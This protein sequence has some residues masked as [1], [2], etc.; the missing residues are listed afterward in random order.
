NMSGEAARDPLTDKNRLRWLYWLAALAPLV[1]LAVVWVPELSHWRVARVRLSDEALTRALQDVRSPAGAQ[2]ERYDLPGFKGWSSAQVLQAAREVANGELTLIDGR[3]ARIDPSFVPRDLDAAPLD[4]E[5]ACLIVPNLHLRAY[6]ATGDA[7]YLGL[8]RTYILRWIDFERGRFL[9]RGMQWNDHA[10]AERVFVLTGF[11]SATRHFDALTRE[12]ARTVLEVLIESGRRL[13]KPGF[14]TFRTNHGLM[15]HLAL[16][17][18]GAN[19]PSMPEAQDMARLAAERLARQLEYYISKEGVILE[20]SAGYQEFGLELLPLAIRELEQLKFE[21]PPVLRERY[22][23]ALD[24]YAALLRPDGSLPPWGDTKAT[25]RAPP[26]ADADA[27]F[28]P[29]AKASQRSLFAPVAGLAVI[30]TP[31][32]QAGSQALV[33]WSDFATGAHKQRDEMSLYLWADGQEVLVG[34]G[35]WPYASGLWADAVGWRGSNAPHFAGEGS[36]SK[37]TTRLLGHASTAQLEFFDL[38]RSLDSG[39]A[40]RRQL[41]FVRP[42]LWIVLDS[43]AASALATVV[44]WT[45]GA[46]AE[47]RAAS[48]TRHLVVRPAAAGPRFEFSTLGC[49]GGTLALQRGSENAFAGWT[50]LS[51]KIEPAWSLVRQCPAGTWAASVLT[52]VS[53]GAG[54]AVRPVTVEGWQ[55]TENWQIS[56]APGQVLAHRRGNVVSLPGASGSAPVEVELQADRRAEQ[57][58]AQINAHYRAM[59]AEFSRYKESHLY[60][61]YKVTIAI[62]ALWLAQLLLLGW[63][64][65]WTFRLSPVLSR[66]LGVSACGFWLLLAVWLRQVYF[67][68]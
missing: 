34:P 66:V 30:W 8:A 12:E 49:E 4:L 65:R 55:D 27:P 28:R 7:R 10:I 3:S 58:Q 45:F 24:V 63:M 64:L 11:L 23:R 59:G 9:P 25:D 62:A 2:L 35:Y 17:H 42:D 5:I 21:V 60:Y 52:Q 33:T 14:Y 43:S 50:A 29:A 54:R 32:A 20:H 18:L 68:T 48:D 46:S 41:L 13:R 47:V 57:E 40:H 1:A 67:S 16:L 37:S 19:L 38:Q 61:R 31:A 51:G 53:E 44:N 39:G 36:T 26:T 6:R 15:Q 56:A 22:A